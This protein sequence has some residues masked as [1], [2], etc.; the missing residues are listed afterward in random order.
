[1]PTICF[2]GMDRAEEAKLK[3]LFTEVNSRLGGEW[4]LVNE[5]QARVLVVDMESMYGHMTWLKAHKTK[6]VIAISS[7]PD[8]EADQVL[9]R[10]VTVDSLVYALGQAATGHVTHAAA[11]TGSH[12]AVAAAPA[13]PPPVAPPVAPAT[14]S[15]K[16]A[17][18]PAPT[19]KRAAEP[20]SR[21]APTTPA[22]HPA[23]TPPPA[24]P[25]SRDPVMWNYL[26]PGGLSGP[27]QLDIEDAP[28]LV[29]DP[30]SDS[31]IGGPT[32]KPYLPYCDLGSLRADRWKSLTGA[33]VN[34]HLTGSN[35]MQP[36]ARLRWLYALVQ[37]RGEL[38]PGYDPDSQYRLNKWPKAEREFPRHMRIA[39]A[40]MQAPGTPADIAIRSDTPQSDVND[41]I[42]ASLESGFAEAVPSQPSGT[43]GGTKSGG[44]LSRLRGGR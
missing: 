32:L 23:P 26:Q 28:S 39:T 9:L 17:A 14:P 35:V 5:A 38:A 40:M 7:H 19:A 6:Q 12:P 27:S 13:A 30:R 21:P 4:S 33:E 22:P 11:I 34:K 41:F 16:P 37:G 43:T 2:T 31:Y 18:S 3:H 24:A 44:L 8:C 25:P 20:P 36:L 1:M 15:P 29:I 42:N 10:P